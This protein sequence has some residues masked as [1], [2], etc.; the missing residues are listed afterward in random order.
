MQGQQR[1]AELLSGHP[2]AC[3]LKDCGHYFKE[4]G[5]PASA[6]SAA[7]AAL[8]GSGSGSLGLHGDGGGSGRGAGERTSR[9]SR[10]AAGAGIGAQLGLSRAFAVAGS[11]NI[12]AQQLQVR[13]GAG[14]SCGGAGAHLISQHSRSAAGMLAA[15]WS[16]SCWLS[17]LPLCGC[18]CVAAAV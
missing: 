14:E 3:L 18:R 8:S 13:Q 9:G 4:G 7:S 12:E 2:V 17:V 15:Y 16:H 5:G 11:A 10:G 6:A 1:V